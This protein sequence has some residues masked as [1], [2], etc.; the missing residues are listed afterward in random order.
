[1]HFIAY[2][3][4][5]PLLAVVSLLVVGRANIARGWRNILGRTLSNGIINPLVIFHPYLSQDFCRRNLTKPL[6]RFWVKESIKQGHAI[7][8]NLFDKSLSLGFSHWDTR[9]LTART[10]ALNP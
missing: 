5:A 9:V 3:H 6:G 8:S 10:I 7:A 1:M 2:P 4:R